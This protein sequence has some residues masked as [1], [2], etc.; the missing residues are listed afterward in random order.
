MSL[1]T[2]G[3]FWSYSAFIEPLEATLHASRAE[4]SAAYTM[5]MALYSICAVPMGWLSDKYGPRRTLW[6]AAFLIGG[7]VT[8]CSL[9]TSLW[10]LY[11]LFGVVAALGHSAI[12]V[13]PMATL[14]RWFIQRRGLA[15][16]IAACGIGFGLLVVPP[17][18]S[19]IIDMYSWQVAFVILGITFFI[20]NVIVGVFI[21]G[22]P[23]DKGL[24][25]FGEI[26]QELSAS[27]YLADTKSF[28]LGEA[29]KTKAFWLLYLVCLFSFAA[30]QMASV[31]VV[32]YSGT[33]GIPATKAVLGLSFLGVGSMVG[34][35][36]SGALSDRIGRV[37][38]L[39]MWCCVEAVAIFCL[40]SV[41]SPV[42]LYLTMLLLGFGYGG[43][44]VL[45]PVMVG[46][47]FGLKNLGTIL[48]VWFT[49]G[50][51][52]SVLGPL[53]GGIVFDLT[54]IYLLAL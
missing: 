37:S 36:G 26:G 16:G 33:V 46:D 28:S 43:W 27:K 42:T 5:F 23:A 48:G 32:P 8:L 1:S 19:Q 18:A 7:S 40:I 15:V 30:E 47:F 14:N 2:Y 17:I 51:P 53:M 6:L 10:Q 9:I 34:R 25:P 38:T 12:F 50:A 11:L 22:R 31:H 39:V 49:A 52:A 35:V 54:K 44:A 21:R 3:L 13:V 4:I 29:L 20:V 24:R 45:C 41:N